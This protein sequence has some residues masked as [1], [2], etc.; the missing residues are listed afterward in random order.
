LKSIVQSTLLD[1][2]KYHSS[3]IYVLIVLLVFGIS[4]CF[5]LPVSGGYDEETHLMRVW[6]MSSFTFVPNEKLGSKMPFPAIYWNLSYRRQPIVRPI[7]PGFYKPYKDFALDSQDYIYS[8]VETRSVYS[9]PLLLPQAL[10]MR[11]LGHR[12]QWSALTVYYAIRLS[13]LITYMLLVLGAVRLAPFG[14]W[15]L[16]VLATAPTAILQAAT[17]SAD[18]ISNG[19]AFLFVGGTLAIAQ[20]DEISWREWFALTFLFT[21]LFFGKVNNL[22]IALLPFI[23]IPPSKFKIRYGYL[24]LIATVVGLIALEVLGWN[25][26]AYSRYHTAIEGADPAG[27]IHFILSNPLKFI[28]ALADT[29]WANGNSFL[30]SSVAIYGYNYWPV[31]AWT[32]YFFWAGILVALFVQE[33]DVEDRKRTVIGLGFTFA[34]TY[35]ATLASLYVTFTP[36]G[37]DLVLGVQGRYFAPAMPLAVLAISAL[38]NLRQLN[39]RAYWPVLLSVMSLTAYLAGMYLSY[40][41]TCGPQFYLPGLCYQPNYK[42]WAPDD[43]YSEPVSSD[44]A[45]EQEIVAECDGMTELRI[46]VD[47]STSNPDEITEFVLRDATQGAEVMRISPHNGELPRKSWFTLTFPPEWDS[48]GNLYILSIRS[49]ETGAIGPRI[50]YSLRPEYPDGKLYENGT[51]IGN[52]ILFQTGCVAGFDKL[53]QQPAP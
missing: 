49:V 27:Q 53:R 3:E 18:P 17:I 47:G 39:I 22:P 44:F 31:P 46:W 25:V 51:P 48:D 7:E 5:L 37:Y 43:L 50:A 4:A 16:A 6:E 40:H 9:P 1:N 21:A 2:K 24:G 20:R 29:I 26:L 14:K 30:Q 41:V 33:N 42:N 15:A 52:D 45:L 28:S 11:Y 12:W 32:Y 13:G 34:A 23:L 10:V 19:I 35:L 36:V 8:G 38:V